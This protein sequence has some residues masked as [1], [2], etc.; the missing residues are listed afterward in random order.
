MYRKFN[1]DFEKIGITNKRFK[2]STKGYIKDSPNDF[3]VKEIMLSKKK[4]EKGI[5]TYFTLK[6]TNW[7]TM[8]SLHK[9]AR[10]CHVSW[11][12][13]LFAGTKDKHA[14][15]SQQ[16]CVKGIK[17]ETLKKLK[18]K[19]I[20]LSNFFESDERINL[21]DLQ[22]NTFVV[23]VNDYE[24]K[25]I[26]EILKN[27]GEYVVKGI[28]NFFA[29]QRFGIQRPNNHIIG[30]LILQEKYELALKELL[31][32]SYVQE[33]ETSRKSRNFLKNNWGKFKE[34]YDLFPKYLNVERIILHY[35][36]SYP[37][38]FVNAFRKLPKNISKIFVYSFQSYIF[39][40]TLSYLIEKGLLSDFELMIPGH[41]SDLKEI[42]GAVM[43]KILEKEKMSLSDFK[44]S[45]YPEIS[46]RGTKRR[47]LIYPTNFK[48]VKITK[49]SYTIEFTLPKGSYATLILRELII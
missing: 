45:S 38:D 42:G 40:L 26:K 29:E 28:P 33:S 47:T 10:L 32:E 43:E 22:G 44:V 37:S 25:N 1:V 27:F 11:K 17:E 3:I 15:T 49:Q 9:I 12:R 35:L 23:T 14:I 16:V 20:E 30:K 13:F 8:Q 18:I 39:N 36:I 6:K 21:G 31:A 41:S 7:T 48:I 34:A 4:K 5:Y 19:D 2:Y 24:C 46:S